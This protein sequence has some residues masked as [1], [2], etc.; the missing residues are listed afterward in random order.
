MPTVVFRFVYNPQIS[1]IGAKF[2]CCA[3][4]MMGGATAVLF[5]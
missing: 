2:M 5:G 3:G 4:M 1:Q